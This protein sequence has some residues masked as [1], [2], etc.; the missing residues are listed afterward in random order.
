MTL[1]TIDTAL[2][3]HRAVEALAYD[4]HDSATRN[5]AVLELVARNRVAKDRREA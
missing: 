5:A 2:L 1:I 3:S 4:G